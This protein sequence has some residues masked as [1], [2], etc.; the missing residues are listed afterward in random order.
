V[1]LCHQC[2]HWQG[3]RAA[4]PET[5]LVTPDSEWRFGECE[6]LRRVL[7]IELY[8]GWDGGTVNTISTPASFGCVEG[9][10]LTEAG[11]P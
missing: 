3:N 2:A 11:K 7:D 6:R 4:Y 9:K 8:T 1:I 10:G 5:P